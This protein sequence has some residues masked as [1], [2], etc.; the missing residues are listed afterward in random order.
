LARSSQ[1]RCCESFDN[2]VRVFRSGTDGKG[3]GS[4]ACRFA[5]GTLSL[6]AEK[7]PNRE[8]KLPEEADQKWGKMACPKGQARLLLRM[9]KGAIKRAM[10]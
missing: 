2:T 7:V 10:R 9:T 3:F 6:F 4:L 1:E 5:V 8:S